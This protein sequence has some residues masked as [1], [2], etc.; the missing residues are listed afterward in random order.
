MSAKEDYAILTDGKITPEDGP[1]IRRLAQTVP[2]VAGLIV[3]F[4]TA[5]AAL[6]GGDAPAAPADD[7]VQESDTDTE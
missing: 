6:L 7:P 1:A 5:L 3:T 2:M 4:L